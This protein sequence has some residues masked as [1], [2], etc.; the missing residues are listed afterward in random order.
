MRDMFIN[1]D[2]NIDKKILPIPAEKRPTELL[3]SDPTL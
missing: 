2:N 1:Y 3:E